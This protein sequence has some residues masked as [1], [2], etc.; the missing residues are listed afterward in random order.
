MK[1]II[2]FI[3]I[4]SCIFLIREFMLNNKFKNNT[5]NNK[6]LIIKDS[7]PEKEGD[8]TS[9]DV[10][11]DTETNSILVNDK[12]NEY[13]VSVDH[14]A[15][16]IVI[17]EN[18]NTSDKYIKANYEKIIP[19]IKNIEEPKNLSISQYIDLYS[20]ISPYLETNMS[21]TELFSI[22]SN[23]NIN[24]LKSNYYNLSKTKKN[25]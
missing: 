4:L 24:N 6:N 5:Q 11:N 14:N 12:D 8:N 2:I 22:V 21:Y 17:N 9:S 1:K 20:K 25:D 19:I 15:K 16:E 18:L 23:I 7:S 3:A 13:T 10:Y